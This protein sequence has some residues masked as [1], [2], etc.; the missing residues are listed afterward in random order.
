MHVDGVGTTAL[1]GEFRPGP[2]DGR[3]D[4][5][6]S[7]SRASSTSTGEFIGRSP[8]RASRTSQRSTRSRRAGCG[9]APT[10]SDSAS[11]TSSA[12]P[13]TR[14]KLAAK[15]AR[16]GKDYDVEYFDVEIGFGD[17]LGLRMQVALRELVAPLLPQVDAGRNCCRAACSRWW[18]SCD[19]VVAAHATRATSTCTASPARSTDRRGP[20]AAAEGGHPRGRRRP[21]RVPAGLEHRAPDPGGQPARFPRRA[22]Q[23][24]RDRHPVRRDPRRGLG[25]P[26]A[27]S[28]RCWRTPRAMPRARACSLNV[29]IAFLPLA[30]ARPAVR[31]G[32][33]GAACSTR[34]RWPPRSSSAASSSCGPSAAAHAV[35]VHVGRRHDAARCA[36]GRH[37]AGLRADPGHQPLRRHDHRRHAVRPVAPGGDRVHVLPGDSD[38]RHRVP[39][40]AVQ[41]ARA[42]V[43][44]TTSASGSSAW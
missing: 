41:G 38:A 43:R 44:W 23:A 13:A 35:R 34:R 16:L 26:R 27:A 9:P 10:R 17:A 4:A 8:R 11:W 19:R 2:A 39:V 28:A 7:C 14:S 3:R 15:L 42:A 36:Q 6:T 33:Q 5:R 21:H 30:A 29:A 18:R 31:Q 24:V 25:V 32:A 37:R 1:S 20:A 12:A 40:L 22:R